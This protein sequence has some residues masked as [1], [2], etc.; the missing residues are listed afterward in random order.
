MF[1]GL[2]KGIGVVREAA[3]KG[4]TGFLTV[5]SEPLSCADIAIG[6]SVAVDGVCLTVVAK[7]GPSLLSFEVV[8]NTMNSTTLKRLKRRDM[9]NLEPSLRLG[10]ALGGHFVS[11]HVDCVGKILSAPRRGV[12]AVLKVAPYSPGFKALTVE[13]GSVAIDGV[14]LTIAA[15]DDSGFTAHIIPHTMKET[16]LGFKKKGDEVNIEFDMLGKYALRREETPRRGDLTEEYLMEN[17]FI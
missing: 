6:D 7:G 11:G 16:T 14:S 9:V 13:K 2:V 15:I 10:D 4:G 17:G 1:T 5:G 3:A 8:S 12:G